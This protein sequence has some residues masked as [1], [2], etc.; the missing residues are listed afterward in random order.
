MIMLSAKQQA[1]IDIKEDLR[2]QNKCFMS[3]KKKLNPIMEKIVNNH[4]KDQRHITTSLWQKHTKSGTQ[5]IAHCFFC[6]SDNSVEFNN[7]SKYYE[8]RQ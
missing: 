5:L 4:L 3:F 2:K 7:Y 6:K 1:I 8:D